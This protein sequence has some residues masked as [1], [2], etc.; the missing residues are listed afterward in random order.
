MLCLNLFSAKPND[1]HDVG[2]LIQDE[3]HSTGSV[4][5]HVYVTYVKAATVVLSFMTL[6]TYCARQALRM[7]TDYWLAE[8]SEASEADQRRRAANGNTTNSISVSAISQNLLTT[9]LPY[10]TA[11][12]SLPKFIASFEWMHVHS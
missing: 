11:E 9:V 6:F 1:E 5:F 8:W 4:K 7:G 12:V 10:L 2:K 3:E